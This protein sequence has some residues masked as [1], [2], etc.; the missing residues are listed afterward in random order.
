MTD[1]LDI[2]SG[3][4]SPSRDRGVVY[5]LDDGEVTDVLPGPGNRFWIV[6][7]I[8]NRTDAAVTAET[9]RPIIVEVLT[10]EKLAVQRDAADKTLREK[11]A[12]RYADADKQ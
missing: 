5:D 2:S 1:A 8:N 12:V 6:K 4:R 3:N 9:A 7:L 11:A 10:G